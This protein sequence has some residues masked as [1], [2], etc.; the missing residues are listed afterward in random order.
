MSNTICKNC[1]QSLERWQIKFCS[2]FCQK[3][4]EYILYISQWKKG[5]ISGSI[6]INTRSISRHI[7]RYLFEKFESRC[8]LCGWNQKHPLTGTIPLDMDH[9]DG[10]S[11]N[12]AENNLRLLCPNCHS[13]TSN[14]KNHNKGKGRKWRVEKYIKNAI[15]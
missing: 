7:K 11:E 9:L 6:G 2:I 12:N 14:F 8:S 4:S 5:S 3:E 10:D 1:K 15:V 13:L